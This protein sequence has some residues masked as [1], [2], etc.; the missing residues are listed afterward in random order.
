MII[1]ILLAGGLVGLWGSERVVGAGVRGEV[2]VAEGVARVG[3]FE[4]TVQLEKDALRFELPGGRGHLRAHA[5]GGGY[6]GHFIQPRALVG[7][8][9]F[10]TPV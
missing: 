2:L 5:E 4:A 8:A 3:G 10:A 1:A 9:P 6:R 7:G